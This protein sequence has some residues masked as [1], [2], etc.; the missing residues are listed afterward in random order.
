MCAQRHQVAYA[1]VND[2]GGI[3][4]CYAAPAVGPSF[5][6]EKG[7][8]I[9]WKLFEVGFPEL[10]WDKLVALLEKVRLIDQD[11]FFFLAHTSHSCM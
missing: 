7:A 6:A 2:I 8:G 5:C 10:S 9:L 11:L 1:T 4:V 3:D